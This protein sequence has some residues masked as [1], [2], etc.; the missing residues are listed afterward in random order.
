V[1]DEHDGTT[2]VS[3]AAS[4]NAELSTAYIDLTARAELPTS[5]IYVGRLAEVV[6]A[7]RTPRWP[8]VAA[9]LAGLAVVAGAT[10][11][12]L[13]PPGGL[14][15]LWQGE[16]PAAARVVPLPARDVMPPS[17]LTIPKIDVST[18]LESLDLD[19]RGEITPPKDFDRAGWYARGVVPG[20]PGP[21]VIAG[22]VDSITGPAVF[23]RLSELKAGDEIQVFAAD[24]VSTFR[25]NR[26]RTFAKDEFP[27]DLVYGPTPLA[28]LRLITCG[29]DFDPTKMSYQDNVVVFA[30]L[31]R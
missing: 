6:Q 24:R 8:W 28:E 1:T 14:V 3:A 2:Y 19:A 30:T 12:A 26:V 21:A 11:A 17:R 23:F 31:A 18:S 16:A 15:S 10:G 29:G 27:T 4:Q 22:H 5:S 20:Q 9:L 7:Q 13:A 25:V